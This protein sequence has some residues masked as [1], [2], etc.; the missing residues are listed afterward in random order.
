MDL[1][2][3]ELLHQIVL[4]LPSSDIPNHRLISKRHASVGADFLFE[5]FLFRSTDATT[6][7]TAS[8]LATN[9]KQCVKALDYEGQGASW[10]LAQK[11]SH[12]AHVV[13]A[14]FAANAPIDTLGALNLRIEVFGPAMPRFAPA[15]ANLARFDVRFECSGAAQ[16]QRSL[17]EFLAGLT[18]LKH[19]ALGFRGAVAGKAVRLRDVVPLECVWARLKDLQ[20][21]D[22]HI[23]EEELSALL[24]NHARTLQ[25]MYFRNLVMEEGTWEGVMRRLEDMVKLKDAGI[26]EVECDGCARADGEEWL[27]KNGGGELLVKTNLRRW[28]VDEDEMLR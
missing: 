20:M 9:L 13:E 16:T 7:R 19:L 2:P 11:T 12:F 22:V 26:N 27:V 17:R 5:T 8:I 15:C 3:T 1:L 28:L 23:T 10:S 6:A 25:T 4:H 14:F 24:G 21:E 18:Q